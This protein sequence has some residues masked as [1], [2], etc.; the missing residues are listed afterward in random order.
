MEKQEKNKGKKEKK[1]KEKKKEKNKEKKEV[2]RLVLYLIQVKLTCWK[3]K[4]EFIIERDWKKVKCPNCKEVNKIIIE[5]KNK[6]IEEY[7]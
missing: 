4:E 5:K 3:C 1:K 2:Q 7:M 6:G